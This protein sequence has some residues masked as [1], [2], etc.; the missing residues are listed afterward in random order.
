MICM[1]FLLNM[2]FRSKHEVEKNIHRIFARGSGSIQRNLGKL[3]RITGEFTSR[4]PC[5]LAEIPYPIN[6]AKIKADAEKNFE[7]SI[8]PIIASFEARNHAGK[9]VGRDWPFSA[10]WFAEELRKGHVGVFVQPAIEQI[11]KEHNVQLE[12]LV[13]ILERSHFVP[14]HLRFTFAYGLL[15]AFKYD[16]VAMAH[17]LSPMLKVRFVRCSH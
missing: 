7:G 8:A 1:C 6:A 10:S 3:Q 5:H 9:V 11:N 13:K 16:F 15:A 2:A 17:V 4:S 14:P 12:D